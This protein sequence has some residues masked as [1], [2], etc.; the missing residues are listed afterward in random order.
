MTAADLIVVG[1]LTVLAAA[2]VFLLVR[3][4]KKPGCRGDCSSCRRCRK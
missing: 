3:R 4:R 1:A 2:A